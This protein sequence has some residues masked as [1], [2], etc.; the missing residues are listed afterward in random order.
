MLQKTGGDW[1]SVFLLAAAVATSSC[2]IFIFL[3]QGEAIDFDK[4]KVGCH[5]DGVREKKESESKVNLVDL[6]ENEKVKGLEKDASF[7]DLQ[8]IDGE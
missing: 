4:R 5:L 8:H 2:L 3:A 1:S 6:E 7:V